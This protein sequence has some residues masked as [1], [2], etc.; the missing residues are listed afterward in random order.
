MLRFSELEHRKVIKDV[1]DEEYNLKTPLFRWEINNFED[2]IGKQKIDLTVLE[3][4]IQILTDEE[5]SEMTSQAE[6]TMEL[7]EEKM[8]SGYFSEK[9]GKRI[10]SALDNT[11]ATF[12]S[13]RNK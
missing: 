3:D 12:K 6:N 1:S 13:I 5:I 2:K 11:L 8:L 4:F 10:W 9:T 7:V